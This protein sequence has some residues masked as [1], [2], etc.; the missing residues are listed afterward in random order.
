MN[1]GEKTTAKL[2][3]SFLCNDISQDPYTTFKLSFLSQLLLEGPSSTM[4]KLLIESGLAPGY[5]PGYG[6]DTT[7]RECLLT[8]GAQNIDNDY[9][10]FNEISKTIM[11]GLKEVA[12]KGINKNL[13]DEVLH[14]IEFDSKKP[15][16][17]FAINM[18]NQG[19]GF[20]THSDSPF[21]LL[22]VNEFSKRIRNELARG[23]KVFENLVKE[24][25][26]NNNHQ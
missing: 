22:L 4:F 6:F 25:L 17:D 18:F 21:S 13:I 11:D 7:I 16:N 19:S 10:K 20:L 23:E 3:I 12:D 15:R 2:G 9:K 8:I 1:L 14:L 24:Y 26:L 5:C